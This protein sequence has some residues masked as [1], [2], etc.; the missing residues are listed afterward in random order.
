MSFDIRLKIDYENW[1]ISEAFSSLLSQEEH[2]D[3]LQLHQR[4]QKKNQAVI[5]KYQMVKMS[6]AKLDSI[7]DFVVGNYNPSIPIHIAELLTLEIESFLMM[8]RSLL[9]IL[10][11]SLAIIELKSSS[12]QSFNQLRKRRDCPEWLSKY[13]KDYSNWS[14]DLSLRKRGWLPLLISFNDTGQSLRDFV[15]H[16][17]VAKYDFRELPFDEGW[18]LIFEPRKNDKYVLP[19]KDVADHIVQGIESLSQ[20][21]RLHF[22]SSCN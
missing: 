18:D 1:I 17:G 14:D 7:C 11:T 13:V 6:K 12:V 21:V 5:H 10:S 22:D 3:D 2:A 16:R 8:S 4:L 9:D 15:T 19:V 20:T